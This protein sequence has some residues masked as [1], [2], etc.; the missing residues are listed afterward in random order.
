MRELFGSAKPII[1]I[2]NYFRISLK[3]ERQPDLHL[4][5]QTPCSVN[6]C[7]QLGAMAIFNF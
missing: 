6:I 1:V 2:Q 3:L 7:P 5:I 4:E